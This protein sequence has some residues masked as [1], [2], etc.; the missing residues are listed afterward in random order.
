MKWFFYF[1]GNCLLSKLLYS[2]YFGTS[3]ILLLARILCLLPIFSFLCFCFFLIY[4]QVTAWKKGM[5]GK[6]LESLDAL[7][8]YTLLLCFLDNWAENRIL[9]WKLFPLK[10]K[11]VIHLFLHPGVPARDSLRDEWNTFIFAHCWMRELW[12]IYLLSPS[13]L[14]LWHF[15]LALWANGIAS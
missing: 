8:W 4:T 7:K 6:L 15:Q 5:G 14:I 11:I 12:G 13:V 10:L 1:N 2:F 9:G 3:I